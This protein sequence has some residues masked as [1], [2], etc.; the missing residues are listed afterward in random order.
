MLQM[1]RDWVSSLQRLVEGP[2]KELWGKGAVWAQAERSMAFIREGD[3]PVLGWGMGETG[4][5]GWG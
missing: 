2:G 1:E 4:G 5:C 3:S